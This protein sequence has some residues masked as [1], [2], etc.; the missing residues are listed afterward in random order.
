MG[1]PILLFFLFWVFSGI[2]AVRGESETGNRLARLMQEFSDPARK[3]ESGNLLEQ[4]F[5]DL[6]S[7]V[8]QG[9]H[10]TAQSYVGQLEAARIGRTTSLAQSPEKKEKDRQIILIRRFTANFLRS[11]SEIET[12]RDHADAA[13]ENLQEAEEIEKNVEATLK[14]LGNPPVESLE[15]YEDEFS[16]LP[17]SVQGAG[18]GFINVPTAFFLALPS[19]LLIPAPV[20]VPFTLLPTVGGPSRVALNN[21]WTWFLGS[22][23]GISTTVVVGVSPS[24]VSVCWVAGPLS[25]NRAL[26]CEQKD[27]RWIISAGDPIPEIPDPTR[28]SLHPEASPSNPQETELKCRGFAGFSYEFRPASPSITLSDAS[29]PPPGNLVVRNVFPGTPAAQAGLEP[30][31][32]IVEYGG[33]PVP[34]ESALMEV[35]RNRFA[36]DEV[37]VFLKR[38]GNTRIRTIKLAEPPRENPGDLETEY[39][40]FRVGSIRLRAVIVS[41]KNMAGK[42]L[43]ALLLVSALGGSRLRD[44]PGFDARRELAYEVAR[45]GFRVMRFELRGMGDSEGEDF[46]LTDFHTETQDNLAALDALMGRADV[47]S[48]NVFVFGHSTGGIIAALLAGKRPLAGLIVSGTVGRS[49]IE[50]VFETVR[51]QSELAGHSSQEIDRNMKEYLFLFSGLLRRDKLSAILGEY[52]ALARFVNAAGRIM[53]DRTIT[54]WRQKLE[55]NLGEIYAQIKTPVLVLYNSADF[56]ATRACHEWIHAT[57][58]AGGNRRV[59]LKIAEKA[60]HRFAQATDFQE[61]FRTY[62]TASFTPNLAPIKTIADWLAGVP[63]NAVEDKP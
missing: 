13:K 61:S 9:K 12:R 55:L 63:R 60:D 27:G 3:S 37:P 2:H 4:I 50:R 45:R 7:L 36:G 46:R 51:L 52:P 15:V 42:P 14:Q 57:L 29:P 54:Y 32:V 56:I 34:D 53:D 20:E 5:A 17:T 19:P 26:S 18:A 43:P 30:G 39:T 8:K 44:I 24:G 40:F 59:T 21:G 31:D 47:V 49:Y 62:K 28:Q 41:P 11:L 33:V 35:I 48:R 38:N 22:W 23:R 58:I 1:L 6:D 25:G 16:P 10:R